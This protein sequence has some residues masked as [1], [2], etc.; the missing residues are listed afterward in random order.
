[1]SAY[2]IRKVLGSDIPIQIF[3]AGE[4]EA[5][6]GPIKT[7]V[8]A[9]GGVQLLDLLEA[10]R[11]QY[12]RG[13]FPHPPSSRVVR[14]Y[15]AKLYALLASSFREN[16]VLDAGAV[17]FVPPE[18]FFS[19]PSY[20]QNHMAI[21]SDYVGL[22]RGRWR[23]VLERV[24]VGYDQFYAA[25]GGRELDSSCVVMD[26]VA[27]FDALAVALALNGELQ[28]QTYTTLIGDKDTWGLAML[29]VGKSFSVANL[30]PGYLLIDRYQVRPLAMPTS[31]P[32]PYCHVIGAV[33]ADA[34][35]MARCC[36]QKLCINGG[37]GPC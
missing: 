10:L 8:E 36:M 6:S 30:E 14:S 4:D 29:H 3:Y 28:A 31:G 11:R 27:N 21:F 34:R 19:L 20:R 22:D 17:A 18:R 25:F 9:L 23:E 32:G 7:A 1:V 37:A 15:A 2:V 35:R 12:P 24:C 16:I 5:F 13:D 26:K 33:D